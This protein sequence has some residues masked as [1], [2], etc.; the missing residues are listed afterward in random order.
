MDKTIEKLVIIS[1]PIVLQNTCKMMKN[2]TNNN[3]PSLLLIKSNLPRSEVARLNLCS[4]SRSD[5]SESAKLM[6][7]QCAF[8]NTRNIRYAVC[9]DGEGREGQIVGGIAAMEYLVVTMDLRR[10]GRPNT[11]DSL[12]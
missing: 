1:E 2:E 7:E 3:L 9:N 6:E 8:Q 11:L 4:G 12:Q 5:Y 10:C